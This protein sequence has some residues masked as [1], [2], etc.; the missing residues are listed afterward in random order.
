MCFIRLFLRKV[1]P[2][3]LVFLLSI[4]CRMFLSSLSF[5]HTFSFFTW[6]VQLIFPSFSR[7]T[8]Q[9]FPGI[10]DLLS[11]GF[12]FQHH[13]ILCSK[14]SISLFSSLNLSLIAGEKSL[15]PKIAWLGAI[16]PH[17]PHSKESTTEPIFRPSTCRLI[18][19]CLLLWVRLNR[20]PL[21]AMWSGPP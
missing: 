6:S 11:E 19:G 7:T 17:K 10:S 3:Q 1:W 18:F 4:V 8:F 9:N 21:A 20:Q 13:T 2:I 5:C 16:N 15:V 14:Y 12:N